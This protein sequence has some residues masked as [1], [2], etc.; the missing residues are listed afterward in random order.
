MSTPITQETLISV[1][2]DGVCI[3]IV[4]STNELVLYSIEVEYMAMK[5]VMK[6][7]IWLQGL[8]ENLGVDHDLLKIN[9]DS[10]SVYLA[11]NQ[12]YL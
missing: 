3:P 9:C 8:L 10:M 1:G 7:A 11:K 6:E 2:L 5:E 4:P 12:V